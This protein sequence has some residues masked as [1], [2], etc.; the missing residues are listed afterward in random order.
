MAMVR[1]HP[2]ALAAVLTACFLWSG[3]HPA[4]TMAE[5]YAPEIELPSENDDTLSEEWTSVA[6]LL[7]QSDGSVEMLLPGEVADIPT[8][9]PTLKGQ[10]DIEKSFTPDVVFGEVKSLPKGEILI[11]TIMDLMATGYSQSGDDFHARVKVAVERDGQTLIPRGALVKG[12][13]TGTEDPGKAL[14]KRAK[15][16]LTFDY[17]LMPDGRKVP[18]KSQYTKGDNALK[19]IGRAVGNGIGGTIGGAIQGVLLGLRFGGLHGAAASNGVTLMASG[20]L[21]AIGGLGRGLAQSGDAILLN[22]GD[23]IKVALEEPLALPTITLPPDT[24]NEIHEPGLNVQVTDYA[25]GRDP[26]KVEN[27]IQLKLAIDNQTNYRFG[28]FDMALMDEYQNVYSVSPFGGNDSM[29][30]F[31]MDPHSQT[32]GAFVF[33]V[34]SPEMRHYIVFYKPYT[35]DIVAKIS[36]TEA[37]K[38]LRTRPE[39]N[40][41]TRKKAKHST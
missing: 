3:L 23:E 1:Q 33:S 13:I 22:E 11:L 36:L 19:A 37:L 9:V 41:A 40:S 12:H 29:L 28:S 31:Q 32:S 16:G 2:K 17:I 35:R 18:F 30:V 27:Q 34:K 24:A 14:S 5:R 7:P 4:L 20:G 21:G 39:A 10:V 8:A 15:I 6:D 38:T 25:L 26:F